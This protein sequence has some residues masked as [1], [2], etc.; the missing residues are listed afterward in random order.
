MKRLPHL[1]LA[2]T[3]VASF[4][5]MVGC[6]SVDDPASS[7]VGSDDLMTRAESENL[8]DPFGG[9]NMLDAAPAFGDA[10]LV[11]TMGE[12]VDYHDP[13]ES[14]GDVTRL[15][16]RERGETML[17]ITWGNLHRDEGIDHL[18]NWD[19]ALRVT[20]GAIVLKKVIRFEPT[21]HIVPRTQRDLL[22]WESTT[23]CCIDGI[24]VRILAQPVLTS[25]DGDSSVDST[26]TVISFR[27]GPLQVEFTLDQLPGLNRVVTLDDGNAVAFQAIHVDP[28]ACPQGFMR[29]IWANHPERQGGFFKGKWETETGRVKGHIKGIYGV[30]DQGEKVFFGKMITR[31][32]RFVGIVVGRYEAN[33]NDES[34][35]IFHGR[36]VNRHRD[37]IGELGGGWQRSEYC[38]GGFFRGRW[39]IACAVDTDS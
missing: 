30:N 9:F 21:D 13:F 8:N 26:N 15:R 33:P 11:S 12:D 16:D 14:D 22:E 19:G 28:D 37:I 5:W 34:G 6:S 2:I 35:G 31:T 39:A 24:L 27:T 23:G 17:A 38:N 3:V 4:A 29:G 32:G 18:T 1:I 25:A 10:E 36:I 20:P 7:N